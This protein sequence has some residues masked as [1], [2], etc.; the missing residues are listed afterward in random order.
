MK[1][2]FGVTVTVLEI[3][4]WPEGDRMPTFRRPLKIGVSRTEGEKR[5]AA[6]NINAFCCAHYQHLLLCLLQT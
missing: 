3:M 5:A 1:L 6:P 4:Y 2:S